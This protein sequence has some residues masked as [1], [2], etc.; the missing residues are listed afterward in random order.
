[1]S[2]LKQIGM[3]VLQYNGDYDEHMPLTVMDSFFNG[4][5][6][7]STWV[8]ST[9]PY[10]KSTQ[11]YRCPSDADASWETPA[12]LYFGTTTPPL[13]RRSSSYQ[14]NAYLINWGYTSMPYAHLS[15]LPSPSKVVYLAEAGSERVLDHFSPM[16]WDSPVDASLCLDGT[17]S[18]WDAA[19]GETTELAIRRHLDGSN[20]L[21]ADG[22]A[23]WQPFSRVWFRDLSAN[24]QI[25]A[26]AF[27]PRQ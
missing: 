25:F 26:G 10:I 4:G 3:A 2:N 19:R 20:F 14:V 13:I 15:A 18:G 11:V 7:H 21:F 23:K 22:H 27:D 8:E 9:Q 24:P 16:C 17:T 1:M 12:S 6:T 5:T